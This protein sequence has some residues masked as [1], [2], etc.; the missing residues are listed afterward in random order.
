MTS[1]FSNGLPAS[2]ALKEEFSGEAAVVSYLAD[3][4]DENI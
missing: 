4:G 3:K 2:I 1:P